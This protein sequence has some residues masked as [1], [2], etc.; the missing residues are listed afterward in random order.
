MTETE[1]LASE[2]P[3]RM[4]E[5]L[6]GSSFGPLGL[7][8][9]EAKI[10]KP[11][12]R[13]LRLFAVACCRLMVPHGNY[14]AIVAGELWADGDHDGAS[15]VADMTLY[16]TLMPSASQAATAAI[17]VNDAARPKQAHLLRDIIGN[18][19][20]PVAL[21][22]CSCG[23]CV[24]RGR[25]HHNGPCAQRRIRTPTVL[26]LATAAYE[27]RDPATGHLDPVRLAILADAL[28]EAGCPYQYDFQIEE[29]CAG[30]VYGRGN[31]GRGYYKFWE[32]IKCG[33]L[34][35]IA[36]QE[37]DGRCHILYKVTKQAPHPVLSHLRSKEPHVR[38]CYILDLILGKN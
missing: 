12:D 21:A 32:C 31:K 8:R 18:P 9:E 22:Q 26:G 19:F 16:W 11:S 7:A 6:V 25:Q 24:P 35:L 4:L 27:E 36:P 2:D 5:F 28:E 14:P 17:R 15:R 33:S 38:G 34:S 37:K 13:K 29:R 20:R 30:Q 10:P 23:S 1:W 3:E